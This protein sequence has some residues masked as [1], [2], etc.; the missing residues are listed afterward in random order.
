MIKEKRSGT[1]CFKR[2]SVTEQLRCKDAWM[3][4]RKDFIQQKKRQALPLC[5]LKQ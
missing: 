5:H 2:K 1:S 3:D 4:D